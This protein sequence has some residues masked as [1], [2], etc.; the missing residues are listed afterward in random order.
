MTFPVRLAKAAVVLLLVVAVGI[1]VWYLVLDKAVA[2]YTVVRGDLLQSVVASGQV[3]TPAR[4]SIA[5]EV[6]GRVTRVPVAEG[7]TVRRGQVLVEL[8]QTDERAAL[9][10]AHAALAQADAK[11]RQIQ[12]YALPAAEQALRQAQANLTQAQRS[13]QRTRDLVARNFVSHAQLDDAQRNLDVAESQLRAAE[14]QVASNRPGGSEFLLAQTARRTAETA[15]SAA[16]AKLDATVIRAPADGVLIGRSVEPGDVAQAGKALMV[17]APAG[18]TQ[19]VVNIDEKNLGKLAIGQKALVSADAFPRE[20]FPAE[21]FY[22]NPGID[23]VRG[24]IEA[25]LR[26]PHPP[27]YLRQDMTVSVDIEIGL[28]RSVLI[29]PADAVHD[30]DTAHPWVLVVRDGRARR[31]PVTLG[32]RGDAAIEIATG[33]AAGDALVPVTNGVV[34]AGQRVRPVPI[35]RRAP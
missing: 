21:L 9:E 16:Q 18:E 10:Q 22:L 35:A 13:W 14:L 15:I 12:Q 6:T 8:D 34:L 26:V 32:M 4:A 23:P 11:L 1:A 33:V 27:A 7:D 28:R 5:A 19:I 31:Q 20:S 30:A 25:K 3:I 29:A 17:I 24:A 2:T